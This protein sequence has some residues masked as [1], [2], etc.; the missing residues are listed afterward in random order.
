MPEES[1][2]RKVLVFRYNI[3]RN[4][5]KATQKCHGLVKE[6]LNLLDRYQ[7]K[8]IV[9]DWI[10]GKIW[11]GKLKWKHIVNGKVKDREFSEW[12]I[13]TVGSQRLCVYRTIIKE[14]KPCIWWRILRVKPQ[15]RKSVQ[16]VM[17]VLS[18]VFVF[19]N[20]MQFQMKEL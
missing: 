10:D 13:E 20:S 18:G 19:Q 3:I 4:S 2:H 9:D 1:L 8:S 14:I 12:R 15:I 6:Y 7:L 5:C 16:T 11:I 17:K